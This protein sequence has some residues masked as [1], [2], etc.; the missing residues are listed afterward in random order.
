MF[1]I[2]DIARNSYAAKSPCARA[3]HALAWQ[4]LLYIIY[5]IIYSIVLHVRHCA[6]LIRCEI[7][8]CTSTSCALIRCEIPMRTSTSC[9]GL[10]IAS[11][12]PQTG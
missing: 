3:P 7:P 6:Q 1:S 4:S 2:F 12:H 9:A 8:M 10:A 5:Y 11:P